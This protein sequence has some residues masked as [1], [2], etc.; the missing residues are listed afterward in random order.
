MK[1]VFG[2][3]TLVYVKE[4]CAGKYDF[5]A[6]LSKALKIYV[7]SFLELED[8]ASLGQVSKH[9]QEVIFFISDCL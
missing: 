1:R 5:F 3:N 4:L 9:F 7:I 6:R 2:V 8:I